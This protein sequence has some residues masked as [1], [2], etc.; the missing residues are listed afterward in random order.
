MVT[1]GVP[2]LTRSPTATTSSTPAGVGFPEVEP[3]AAGSDPPVPAELS[4]S[5]SAS[6]PPA[7]V[8][9]E[10][11]TTPAIGARSVSASTLDFARSYAALAWACW[12]VPSEASPS[13]R[14]AI[15]RCTWLRICRDTRAACS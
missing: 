3:A 4:S 5:L 11:C 10:I 9:P 8:G 15:P 12:A 7:V 1:I 6:P 2:A 14:L 13:A